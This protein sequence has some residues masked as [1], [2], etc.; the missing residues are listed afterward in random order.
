[1]ITRMGYR[2]HEFLDQV[3][4]GFL[5]TYL[6][7]DQM[8]DYM[9]GRPEDDGAGVGLTELSS[10]LLGSYVSR[11]VEETPSVAFRRHYLECARIINVL[12]SDREPS[13]RGLSSTERQKLQILL[14]IERNE[15]ADYCS[16]FYRIMGPGSAGRIA[17]G[18]FVEE[19]RSQSD[20]IRDLRRCLDPESLQGF[21]E[22]WL[23]EFGQPS[24]PSVLLQFAQVRYDYLALRKGCEPL[25]GEQVEERFDQVGECLRKKHTDRLLRR[26]TVVREKGERAARASNQAEDGSEDASGDLSFRMS[27][28]LVLDELAH[29]ATEG[30]CY[31]SDVPAAR[32]ERAFNDVLKALVG[33]SARETVYDWQRKG[34]EKGDGKQVYVGVPDEYMEYLFPAPEELI[35]DS[36]ELYKGLN[37]G[38]IMWNDAQENKASP[39]AALRQM[40]PV[41]SSSDG[42]VRLCLASPDACL[43]LSGNSN[44]AGRRRAKLVE[45]GR[46]A[47]YLLFLPGD[48]ST[49]ETLRV[50]PIQKTSPDT[51]SGALDEYRYLETVIDA[52]DDAKDT[53]QQHIT[54][55]QQKRGR[56]GGPRLA[57]A[58]SRWG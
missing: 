45:T 2:K 52:F 19:A 7:S 36:F 8:D 55:G 29:I 6:S 40:I 53:T 32:A 16:Q 57:R 1:M 20:V 24:R 31:R 9:D 3:A 35:R 11:R 51:R 22:G 4:N 30:E 38:A 47:L 27:H 5:A 58:I 14:Q 10:S 34:A 43:L 39:A 33:L 41:C 18:R 23:R 26:E 17:E 25:F 12:G 42:G 56:D 15:I 46:N 54:F 21:F 13:N 44:M 49:G 37:S 48:P 50:Q 28:K